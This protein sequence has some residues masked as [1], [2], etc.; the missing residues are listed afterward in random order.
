MSA[1]AFFRLLDNHGTVIIDEVDNFGLFENSDKRGI[2]NS[3]FDQTAPVVKRHKETFNVFAPLAVGGIGSLPVTL[4]SR[5]L[6][7]HL[8][9][10]A[11]TYPLLKPDD[12]AMRQPF[13]HAAMLIEEWKESVKL[14]PNP[15]MPDGIATRP[16]DKWRVLLSIADSISAA[17]GKRARD[18]AI[19][20]GSLHDD[21]DVQTMLLL[22]C[23]TVFNLRGN[24]DNIKSE[25]LC[26]DLLENE[27]RYPW[28]EYRGPKDDESP[29]KLRTGDVA[30]LL[31]MFHI[32]PKKI[33][34]KVGGP[35]QGYERAW[36]QRH[37]EAKSE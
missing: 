4:T 23:E 22:D 18:A 21:V 33:R 27:T 14:N 12:D 7:I 6:S 8:W 2:I 26:H 15:A 5:S 34:F 9:R 11:K 28:T 30:R 19:A 25:D 37:W 36:F 1:A 20:F 29:H 16:A 17:W 10:S 31:E 24:P 35:L 32:R 13:D 3:G